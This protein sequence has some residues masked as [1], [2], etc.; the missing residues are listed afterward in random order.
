MKIKKIVLPA[1]ESNADD[2]AVQ[3]A[4]VTVH[5]MQGAKRERLKV[6]HS[7]YDVA[8]ILFLRCPSKT[9]SRLQ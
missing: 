9:S 3:K 5:A 6:D 4:L 7:Q 2:G 1:K 8:N